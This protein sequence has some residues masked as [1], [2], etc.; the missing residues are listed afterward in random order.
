LY[1]LAEA[2]NKD[3]QGFVSMFGDGGYFYNV[4]AAKKYYGQD[5]GVTVD[6]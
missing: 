1:S 2:A 6:N 4:G 3:T 5:I